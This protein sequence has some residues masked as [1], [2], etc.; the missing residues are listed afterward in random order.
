MK[1]WKCNID[2]ISLMPGGIQVF[3]IPKYYKLDV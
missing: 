1:M 2:T 3:T